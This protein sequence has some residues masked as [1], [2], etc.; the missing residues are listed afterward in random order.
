[1]V[2]GSAMGLDLFADQVPEQIPNFHI[3]LTL[4]FQKFF[5]KIN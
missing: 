1:M 5:I 3:L 4:F 2:K